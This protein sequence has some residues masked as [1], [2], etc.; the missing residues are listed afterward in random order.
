MGCTPPKVIPGALS[1]TDVIGVSPPNVTPTGA[2]D[3][4]PAKANANSGPEAAV[5][6][7][8]SHDQ[9]KAK[10]GGTGP[11]VQMEDGAAT[12]PELTASTKG[13]RRE[14]FSG[15]SPSGV[16]SRKQAARVA[17]CVANSMTHTRGSPVVFRLRIMP[18]HSNS[19]RRCASLTSGEMF[20]TLTA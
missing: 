18:Q 9:S 17:S 2:D 19:S 13:S 10:V 8:L 14:I 5:V 7:A 1:A 11:D 6:D 12:E 15:R 4:E 16:P 20:V 3:A